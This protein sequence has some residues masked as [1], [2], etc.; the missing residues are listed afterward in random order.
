MGKVSTNVGMY[1]G[2]LNL[3]K[4]GRL[5]LRRRVEEDSIIPG[6]SF[7]GNWELPGGAVEETD[8]KVAYNYP[9]KEAV[10]ETV[11]EVGVPV[12]VP[13]GMQPVYLTFFKGPK[14]Y[15]LAG[16]V[17][18]VTN[19]EATRGETI[20]VSPEELKVLA[21]AFVPA[22][23]AKGQDGQG[24]LSGW[25]KRMCCMALAALTHSPNPT[26]SQQAKNMLA[27]ISRDW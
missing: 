14:G 27:E 8:G 22:D 6:K 19:Q 3:N 10:R 16:V 5:L 7:K 1:L 21:E 11:E 13:A 20:Y 4:E 26:F 2:L 25:G 23:K 15:D 9:I 24:L 12:S 17:P 18:V